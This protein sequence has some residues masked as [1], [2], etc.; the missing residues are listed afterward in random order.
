MTERTTTPEGL[1]ATARSRR[2]LL[3][4]AIGAAAAA[5]ATSMARV[6]PTTA[7]D[8]DEAILGVRNESDST[9]TFYAADAWALSGNSSSSRGVNGKSTDGQGVHGESIHSAGVAGV[10]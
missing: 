10:S 2:N 6:T 3:T 7:D 8:G 4:A 9:T 1:A 5:V